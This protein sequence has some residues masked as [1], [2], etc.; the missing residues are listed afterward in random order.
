MKRQVFQTRSDLEQCQLEKLNQLI[1]SILAGNR[2]YTEK[3]GPTFLPIRFLSLESFIQA[4]PFTTKDEIAANQTAFPPFGNNLSF[5]IADYVRFHQTTGTTST[6]VRW[7][8]TAAGWDWLVENWIEVFEAAGVH[9]GDRI[10][11]TF[12]FGPFLGFWLAFDAAQKLGAMT[13]PA[14]GL[15]S[16]ARLKLLRE[17]EATVLC[18]TPT[19]AFRLAEVAQKEKIPLDQ[20]AL[21]R[22]M[23][24]GEAGGSIPAT[25]AALKKLWPTA[26]VFDHHGMTEVG[27]VTFECPEHPG[28]LHIIERSYLAEIIDPKTGS[29]VKTGQ[30]GELVLT[31]LGREASPLLRYRTND[32]VKAVDY[33]EAGK[34]LCGRVEIALEGGILGRVDDMVIVRGVNIYPSA[35][36]D[37]VRSHSQI[38]EYR[39]VV[40]HCQKLL[41][42][43]LEVE[44]I[45]GMEADR[46]AKSLATELQKAFNIR[47]PVVT[48]PSG[49]ITIGEMKSKRWIHHRG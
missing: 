24:A 19:Y 4:S 6:P 8:D 17:T 33:G 12:S 27:P 34:C 36:E 35:I 49:T 20:L 32:F 9:S 1:R 21:R 5:P 44:I 39:V 23:V 16:S 28:R 15:S 48:L 38:S 31:P 26:S 29:A 2:F 47:I 22:I 45:A 10:L 14:G 40:D 11:F 3:L 46:A 18:C 25:R 13:I 43:R 30:Q 42:L 37:F 41:E 7:L